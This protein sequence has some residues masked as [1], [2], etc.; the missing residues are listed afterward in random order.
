MDRDN[1]EERFQ[2]AKIKFLRS[3]VGIIERERIKNKRVED[4]YSL[5]GKIN[6]YRNNWLDH[7][8]KMDEEK[9]TIKITIGR[10]WKV[11]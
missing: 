3:S 10:T 9:Q 5:N 7:V 2:V 6:A 4:I 8:Q 11:L 1:R